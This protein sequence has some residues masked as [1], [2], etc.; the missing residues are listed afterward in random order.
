MTL[1]RLKFVPFLS[2]MSAQNFI[3]RFD[4]EPIGIFQCRVLTM[5]RKVELE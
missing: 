3:S 2:F 1:P 5:S 4:T